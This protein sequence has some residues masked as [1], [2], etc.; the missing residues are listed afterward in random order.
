MS[1]ESFLKRLKEEDL[2]DEAVITKLRQQIGR[3]NAP[4]PAQQVAG[5]LVD[6]GH[7]TKF[8]AKK[9][10]EGLESEPGSEASEDLGLAEEPE[11]TA[12]DAPPKGGK[13]KAAAGPPPAPEKRWKGKAP[14]PPAKK[15]KKEKQAASPAPA[16][17][18]PVDDGGG[19]Q[20]L[21]SDGLQPLADDGLQPLGNDDLQP[22]GVDD[23][24]TPVGGGFGADPM[25]GQAG[26]YAQA[27][28]PQP[29]EA[30]AASFRGKKF[31]ENQW[32]SPWL[33]IGGGL[34]ILLLLLGGWL[35]FVLT[36]GDATEMF[37][38]SDRAYRQESYSDAIDKYD[39]FLEKFPEDDKAPKA[40]VYRALAKLWLPVS[41]KDWERSLEVANKELPEIQSEI[42]DVPEARVQLS[43]QLTT[44]AQGIA[45][46]AV[47]V[48][49]TDTEAAK[50]LLE[51]LD[52][53]ANK[54]DAMDLVGNPTYV[55]TAER[56]K[57]VIKN[58]IDQVLED[59]LRVRRDIGK[60]EELVATVKRMTEAAD[61]AKTSEAFEMRILLMQKYGEGV[62]SDERVL[63]TVKYVAEKERGLVKPKEQDL[64]AATSAKLDDVTARVVLASRVG[65]EVPGLEQHVAVFLARGSV[66]ALDAGTGRVLWRRFVGEETTIRPQRMS[67]DNDADVV[68][69]DGR[70]NSVLRVDAFTGETKWRVEI[71]RAFAAPII[72][73]D[74]IL[75][76]DE[77]GRLV[78]VNPDT[79]KSD[80]NVQ[81]PQSLFVGPGVNA[82]GS[83]IYQVGEHSNIYV[84]AASDMACRDVLYLGH[85]AGSA[86]TAPAMSQGH[87]FIPVNSGADYCILHVLEATNRGLNLR[88][89][90]TIRLEGHVVV[91]L[92]LYG[93][94]LVA[95]TDLGAVHVFEIDAADE[96]E[97]V[98]DIARFA[99]RW[100]KP[101]VGYPIAAAGYL[102]VADRAFSIFQLQTAKGEISRLAV[103]NDQDSFLAPSQ[104]FGD[105]VVHVRQRRGEVGATVTAVNGKTGDR[106]WRTDLSV[107]LAG[108]VVFDQSKGAFSL[109]TAQASLFEVKLPP[110]DA[111]TEPKRI[112]D[113]DAVFQ[114]GVSELGLNVR[115]GITFPD[116]LRTFSGPAGT[117][118]LLRLNP[119]D[120]DRKTLRFRIMSIPKG[121]LAA[122]PVEFSNGMLVPAND[123]RIY[124]VEPSMGK[125]LSLPFQPAIEPGKTL[126]WQRPTVLPSGTQFLAVDGRDRLHLVEVVSKPKPHLAAKK[127]VELPPGALG[128]A[129]VA[130]NRCFVA[131]RGPK[132]D[133][134]VSYRLSDLGEYKETTTKVRITWGPHSI[135]DAVVYATD[136]GQ[137]HCVGSDHDERWAVDFKH[138]FA[139]SRP[140]IHQDGFLVATGEGVIVKLSAEAGEETG[141]ANVGEPLEKGP[142]LVDGRL[143][144]VGPDGTLH[145]LP[146]IQ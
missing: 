133:A 120:P 50:T 3:S 99:K 7:L 84:I 68:F 9:L 40:R 75:V 143:I 45:A 69:A 67:P 112:V 87:L 41:S 78:E 22:L 139:V 130:G 106:I 30:Q 24:L 71:G 144:A 66:F 102:W 107:P 136:N 57:P 26:M 97:P 117:E 28:Q 92:Q 86:I 114:A 70:D 46:D 113:S 89:A 11:L 118:R 72:T 135:G 4:V 32:D 2:I 95:V 35:V 43:S 145:V 109:V 128:P 73:A 100:K 124:H 63:K 91:P 137:M 131:T 90:Q 54:N 125:Q 81:F 5:L 49:R 34:L 123:G 108:D 94:R 53:E 27:P 104:V 126:S 85:K 39:T 110:A 76:A 48:V 98:K 38:A 8:Q 121:S 82:S 101:V 51:S 116:G 21:A 138:G 18:A 119:K 61:L 42:A 20:P 58:R 15:K 56:D 103:L 134:L 141:K 111:G 74:R 37:E 33:L 52:S 88:K 47:D 23:G 83:Y 127:H 96:E 64:D 122:E 13:T 44:I 14:P 77:S 36:K 19:L 31:R 132:V 146:M 62:G 25:A 59:I 29:A 142:Y 16:A 60:E 129:A 140:L 65:N 80:R 115:Y 12:E 6:K 93:R 55:P 1:A 17:K 105:A 79:G 10:L